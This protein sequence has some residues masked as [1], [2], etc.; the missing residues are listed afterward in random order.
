MRSSRWATPVLTLIVLIQC[1]AGASYIERTAIP[2]GD[3]RVFVLWDDA[4]ISMRFAQNLADGHG[5]VWNPGEEPVQGYTNLGLTLVM[6]GAHT[7]PLEREHVSL[8]IQLLA[9]AALAATLWLS[10][11]LARD[12]SG[13]PWAAPGVAAAALLCAP[14]QIYALQGADTIF[15]ALLVVWGYSG[16]VR[17]W[18]RG[19]EWPTRCF[20]PLLVAVVVRPDASLFFAAAATTVVLFPGRIGRNTLWRPLTG[21]AITWTGLIAFSW[22]YYGDPLPN[23]F[24]LK[25]T[26]AA[27]SEM[28]ASGLNQLRLL[29]PGALPAVLLCLAAVLTTRTNAAR[30]AAFLLSTG[31]GLGVAYHVWVGGDWIQE[32]G[33]RHWVQ[34]V[35]LVL[36]LAAWGA[37][38]IGAR[39]PGDARGLRGATTFGLCVL[40]G[41][42]LNLPQPAREWFLPET[43]TLLH[44]E[45]HMNLMRSRF[46]QRATSADTRVAVHWAGVGP[47]F[48]DRPAI[49]VLGRSDRHIAHSPAHTFEPGHSKWDWDYILDERRPDLIDFESRGLRDHPSFWR[50]YV[51]LRVGP[52]AALFVRRDATAK[53]LDASLVTMPLDSLFT[54]PAGAVSELP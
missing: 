16:L 45:N 10:A 9:L 44:Q 11:R 15:V 51:V 7:L 35:P 8:I 21:F 46:L 6:A 13:A 37:A 42:S 39:L 41:A 33:S 43:P 54:R 27:R 49:D 5:L 40:A 30:A 14:H 48:A 47:Y 50:D 23:T 26:G 19:G 24:Y 34:G 32:Y 4:M 29:I 22:L 28:W 53:I 12:L 38:Q 31:V 1:V 2:D 3:Q 20:V 17:G 36:T 18:L 52:S 25:A